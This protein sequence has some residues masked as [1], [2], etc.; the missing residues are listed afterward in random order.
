MN[1]QRENVFEEIILVKGPNCICLELRICFDQL[2]EKEKT[3]DSGK[4]E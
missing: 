2:Q 4:P 1:I 3:L